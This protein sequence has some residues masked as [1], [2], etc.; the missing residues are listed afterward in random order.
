LPHT[1]THSQESD[2]GTR[3]PPEVAGAARLSPALNW[4]VDGG[5]KA[6]PRSDPSNGDHGEPGHRLPFSL[7][8]AESLNREWTRAAVQHVRS[9]CTV[10]ARVHDCLQGLRS[11]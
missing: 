4:A 8:A 10:L 1:Y 9:K 5:L 6:I 3:T 7:Y 2:L 11:V